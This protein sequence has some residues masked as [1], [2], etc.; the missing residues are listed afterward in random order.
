V[1]SFADNLGLSGANLLL[2]N[3]VGVVL[4]PS[5]DREEALRDRDLCEFAD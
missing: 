3:S 4:A 2:I 5:V 1:G